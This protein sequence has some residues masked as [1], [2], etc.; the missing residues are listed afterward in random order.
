MAREL[1]CLPSSVPV[2]SPIRLLLASAALGPLHALAAPSGSP[3]QVASYTGNPLADVQMSPSAPYADK[4]RTLAIPRLSPELAAKAAKV[5][6]VPSFQWLDARDKIPLLN[7]TLAAIREAN[8]A[9]ASPP[10]AAT[11]VVYNFP[12]RDCS[13]KASAGELVLADGG[14][15]KYEKEFIDPI[16][17]L[18]DEYSDV[19]QVIVYEPDGLANLVTNM[20]VERCANAAPAYL[21][22]TEYALRAFDRPNAAVYLDAGHAGWLGWDSNL[23]PTARVYGAAYRR[24]GSPKAVRGLVTNVSNFNAWNTS[25]QFDYT[26]PN[27]NWDESK[28]HAALAPHLVEEGFPARFIVDQGRSGRQPTNRDSWAEWCNIKGAGFGARPSADT[29][30]ETLD[31]FVWVKP[32]GEADG[33]SDTAAERYDE[34]CGSNS[35]LIPAPEAGAWFQEYFVML[36]QNANPP[37]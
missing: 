13:A 37:F 14:L 20:E 1:S 8:R 10:F 23:A 19:R 35:S 31:A 24:A 9:G 18:I 2:M 3:R 33:T 36:L 6:E 17:A 22:A 5:A 25:V 29:G 26:V 28:F 21:S 7:E 34:R 11:Y 4:I 32:G 15:A 30:V 27:D 12:D 16:A